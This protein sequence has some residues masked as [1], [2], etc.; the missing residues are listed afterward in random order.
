M[1]IGHFIK[2]T[3]CGAK[4][5]PELEG[6]SGGFCSPCP[7]LLVLLLACSALPASA[8]HASASSSGSPSQGVSSLQE[9]DQAPLLGE[10]NPLFQE[11]R[12]RMLNAQRQ[13]TLVADTNKLLQLASELNAELNGPHPGPL[14]ASQLRKVAEIEKLARSVRENMSLSVKGGPLLT[15]PLPVVPILR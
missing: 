6:R 12:L 4:V 8:Q 15:S 7:A 3:G 9:W 11:R 14:T 5:Q 13:K 1:K 10:N 2:R